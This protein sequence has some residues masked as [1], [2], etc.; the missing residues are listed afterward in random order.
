LEVAGAIATAI[1]TKTGAYT[2]INTDS[3]ILGDATSAAFTL[4]LPTAVGIAGRIYTLKKIDSS[5]NAVTIDG[6][7]AETIDGEATYSLS[8]QWKYVSIQSDG[9]NWVIIGNN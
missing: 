2:L 8:T 3:T 6:N 1:A 5:V 9:S 7:G 4:T